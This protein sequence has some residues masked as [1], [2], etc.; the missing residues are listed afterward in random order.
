MGPYCKVS[1]KQQRE[2]EGNDRRLANVGLPKMA[3]IRLCPFDSS[4]CNLASHIMELIKII[5]IIIIETPQKKQM[6]ET[7]LG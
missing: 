3:S 1:T 2:V 6:Y 7:K 5:I 4:S